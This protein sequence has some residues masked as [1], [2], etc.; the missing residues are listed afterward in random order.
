VDVHALH[1]A[2]RYP[3]RIVGVAMM[4]SN[5]EVVQRLFDSFTEG[6]IEAALD[7]LSEDLV[8]EIPPDMSAEPDEYHGH[9]GARRYFDGFDGMIEQ[10]RYEALELIP[11]GEERVL[12]HVRLSGRGA[13]SGLD[14]ALEPYVM[15]ELADG[16]I[17]RIRPYP[18]R[19]AAERAI[20]G[21]A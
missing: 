6:G 4:D 9:E 3:S 2:A 7:G 17:I 13:S 20:A 5:V 8:I 11:V 19:E 14:V 16:K 1:G 21:A 15:H 10:L 12:A 18:D